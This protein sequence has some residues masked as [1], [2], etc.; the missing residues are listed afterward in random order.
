MKKV[1]VLEDDAD[2]RGL[3]AIRLRH[4]GYEAVEAAAGAEA[5]DLLQQHPDIR[6]VLLDCM[7]PDMDGLDICRQLR[8][9][10]SQLG[11]IILSARSEEA[12]KIAGLRSGADDYVTKPFSP[13]ELMARTD[14]LFR[15]IGTVP[16]AVPAPVLRHGP[17]LLNIRSRTLEKNGVPIRLTQT[18]YSMIRLFLEHP[19]R[20]ISREEIL[21]T[22]WGANYFGELKIVDVNIRRLRI[23]IEDDPKSPVYIVTEWGYGYKWN[24]LPASAPHNIPFCSHS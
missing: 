5:L 24:A 18:E 13:A 14:A 7:L 9:A 21:N 22:V 12:D 2:T 17:F 11:I 1:L 19:G 23:K 16:D 8:A 20:A 10:D 4:S 3:L 6:I 15:R